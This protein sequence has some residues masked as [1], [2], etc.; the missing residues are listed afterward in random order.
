MVSWQKALPVTH[1]S[2]A[3]GLTA[4]CLCRVW[5]WSGEVVNAI[6]EAPELSPGAFDQAGKTSPELPTNQQA[7]GW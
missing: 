6:A 2:L 3:R 7:P 4:G 1:G 5:P